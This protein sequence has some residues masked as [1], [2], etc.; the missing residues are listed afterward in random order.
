MQAHR[1]GG[2]A[3]GIRR[4]RWVLLPGFPNSGLDCG[5][6][7]HV[8]VCLLSFMSPRTTNTSVARLSKKRGSHSLRRGDLEVVH[9]LPEKDISELQQT[10]SRTQFRECADPDSEVVW[11]EWRSQEQSS[12]QRSG[13]RDSRASRTAAQPT[14]QVGAHDASEPGGLGADP[15][16]LLTLMLLSYSGDGQGSLEELQLLVHL[17]QHAQLILMQFEQRCLEH[18]FQQIW[19]QSEMRSSSSLLTQTPQSLLAQAN[20]CNS[21]LLGTSAL[22]SA[23]GTS[24]SI[25]RT[26]AGQELPVAEMLRN[27]QSQGSEYG[28]VSHEASQTSWRRAQVPP[29]TRRNV[30]GQPSQRSGC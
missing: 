14:D 24:Q 25:L 22:S 8:R 1:T 7:K 27:L 11:G 17:A 19:G 30:H 18:S 12:S 5:P 6:S 10:F 29:A 3:F 21:S 26:A 9:E 13:D 28:S 23:V 4:K 16:E 15:L 20:V 2:L